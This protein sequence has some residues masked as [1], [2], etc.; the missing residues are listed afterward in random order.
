M[1]DFLSKNKPIIFPSLMFLTAAVL[2]C[3][4]LIRSGYFSVIGT[5]YLVSCV[6]FY[7]FI[8]F[9]WLFTQSESG[10]YLTTSA[11]VLMLGN[12]SQPLLNFGCDMDNEAAAIV[13]RME[14]FSILVIV[15]VIAVWLI[16][17]LLETLQY[18]QLIPT[19]LCAF[20]C[21]GLCG[22]IF[23]FSDKESN[24]STIL[25]VQPAIIMCFLILYCFAAFLSK[26]N[27][28]L[29][30]FTHL[31]C[32]G[33]MMGILMYK[34]EGGIPLIC[35]ISC[36][37]MYVL[38]YPV[39][40]MRFLLFYIIVPIAILTIL[41]MM[42]HDLLTDTLG[43]LNS[44]FSENDQTNQAIQNLK[45]SGLFGR[46]SYDYYL[47]AASTDFSLNTSIHYWGFLWGAIFVLVFIKGALQKAHELSSPHGFD[48]SVNLTNLSFTA[49]CVVIGY[50][51]LV[52]IG[53]VPIVGVQALFCGKSLSIAILSGL[54][55]GG[56]T[57][58]KGMIKKNVAKIFSC[59]NQSELYIDN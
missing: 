29:Y 52:S 57:Y 5:E 53:I 38:L 13:R 11:S 46:F 48:L 9:M 56:I 22:L 59:Y 15:S 49:F 50:N 10:V 34:H 40:R 44:R 23:R 21:V 54:L 51:L 41:L 35:Y 16:L 47:P 25:S 3:P 55:L 18:R 14:I 28:K 31:I 43:K 26:D 6:L 7:A 12:W 4:S 17:S 33:A 27:G 2:E 24:T 20:L 58:D 1:Q 36:L 42:D 39:S 30:R 45:L 8:L 37:T 32:F 19:I